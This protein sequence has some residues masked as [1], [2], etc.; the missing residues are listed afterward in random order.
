MWYHD[1]IN[2]LTTRINDLT[3]QRDQCKPP[4]PYEWDDWSDWNDHDNLIADLTDQRDA[5]QA[6]IPAIAALETKIVS[7]D[8]ACETADRD[9][10]GYSRTSRRL[11]YLGGVAVLL[12]GVANLLWLP[13]MWLLLTPAVLV[14]ACAAVALRRARRY[15]QLTD[16]AINA[17]Y[18]HVDA[19]AQVE[20]ILRRI[21]RG[22]PTHT[23]DI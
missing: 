11:A 2:A 10:E 18:E 1:E 17:D 5:M 8:A 19:Q 15:H 20:L 7:T 12:A 3:E 22:Q 13:T 21:E 6:S 4:E 14:I 23:A 9:L 16:I